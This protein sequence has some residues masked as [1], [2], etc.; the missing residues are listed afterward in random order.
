MVNQ[1]KYGANF[2]NATKLG[3]IFLILNIPFMTVQNLLSELQ[4]ANGFGA[5]GFWLLAVF[6]LFQMLG[7][8]IS[9]A[10]F[11]KIGMKSTFIF[12]GINLSLVVLCQIVPALR[13]QIKNDP[14]SD[15]SGF[16]KFVTKDQICIM[17]CYL[18]SIF[19]GF[20]QSLVWVAQGEYMSSCGTDETAGFYFGYFW[21]WYMS[22]NIIGNWLGSEMIQRE[23]G[24]AFFFIMFLIMIAGNAG[25]LFLKK[26]HQDLTKT[27]DSKFEGLKSLED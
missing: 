19:G 20:G 22:T 18:G 25:F 23:S 7:S 13:S 3:A 5:L 8:V 4:K 17:I 24:P 10:V 6:Y 27:L 16:V 11:E 26:P 9:A 1:N 12:G 2:L 21:V 14:D 15:P